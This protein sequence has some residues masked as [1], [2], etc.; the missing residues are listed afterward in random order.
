MQGY[1]SNFLSSA[2]WEAAFIYNANV[3]RNDAVS[4]RL[5]LILLNAAY[6]NPHLEKPIILKDKGFG[7]NKLAREQILNVS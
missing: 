6:D 5:L 1:A 7:L 2:I 3:A 4:E